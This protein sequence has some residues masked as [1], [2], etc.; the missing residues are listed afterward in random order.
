MCDR[1]WTSSTVQHRYSA[2]D[3]VEINL[4]LQASTTSLANLPRLVTGVLDIG[5]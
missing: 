1:D 4:F 3:S 5:K 2:A